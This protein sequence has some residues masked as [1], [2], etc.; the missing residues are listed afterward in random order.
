[1]TARPSRI[2]IIGAGW[3]ASAYF[4][5]AA[6]FP[7][8]F[9]FVGALVRTDASAAAI[10]ADRGLA[11]T[12]S[13]VDFIRGGPYDYVV[14]SVPA[15]DASGFIVD[16]AQRGIPVLTETPPATNLGA[17]LEL[18][19]NIP[20]DAPIQVAEQYRFQ[21]QHAARLAV[22]HS[23]ILGAVTSAYASV[24]HDYHGISLL[25][26]LLRTG[27]EDVV[28]TAD[29]FADVVV[30]T[31][32]REGWA[33][34]LAERES[35]RVTARIRYPGLGLLGVYE[36][37]GE[38]YFSPVRSRHI[39]AF[40][41]HGELV[42]D[43]IRFMRG[44]GDDVL[45]QLERDQTGIDGDLSGSYLRRITFGDQVVYDNPLSPGRLSDDEIAIG[46]VLK[47]MHGYVTDGVGFY[48]LADASQDT[49]LG[50]LIAEAVKS[51]CPVRSETQ[52]WSARVS[53]L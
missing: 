27:G 32:G 38:Q 31:L 41:S 24:A 9:E 17:L 46:T 7:D 49:Y 45:L 30:A 53:R 28:V 37:N 13:L 25:R 51:G 2:G 42:D 3:R 35:S 26:A 12:T 34:E 40:G 4:T 18:Y 1:M 6:A 39:S 22:A 36:F 29:S 43:V 10:R 19:S 15:Q 44:P 50:F 8:L 21:P 47:R 20:A 52:P 48:D 16:L 23:G 33:P 11:A 5:I 14:L